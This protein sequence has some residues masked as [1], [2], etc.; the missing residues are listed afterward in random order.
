MEKDLTESIGKE[1]AALSLVEIGLGSFLHS[2]KIPFAG[3]LL[4]I[5]QIVILSRSSFK[6]KSSQS[7]LKISLIAA[8]LKS[9][10]PAG[11][12]LTPMLALAAQGL[13]FSLG[14]TLLGINYLGL[15]FAVLLSSLWA[16]IQPI[17]FILLLFGK[18]TIEVADYFIHEFEK[19][20]PHTDKIII[21][22][23][24]LLI[25]IKFLMTFVL[26]IVVIKMSDAKFENYQNF[27]ILKIKERKSSPT[28]A[29]WMALRDLFNPLFIL[30]FVL[31]LLFFVYSNASFAQ[32]IWALLRPM[33]IG[34]V[35]FYVIRVYPIEKLSGYFKRKGFHQFSK[36]LEVAIN[37]VK[38][39][40]K[41]Y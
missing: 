34:Y 39:N 30:T 5:N 7:P 35:F 16:F 41:H 13:L 31:T 37:A 6:L 1:A 28:S 33:A 27:L 38:K 36:S 26:S 29:A 40:K 25:I 20:I 18:T 15:I 22:I 17:L 3:H 9:L 32:T 8:L 19:V 14:I 2:F 23:V 21:W 24:A 10:S 4:S 12:K 11:K